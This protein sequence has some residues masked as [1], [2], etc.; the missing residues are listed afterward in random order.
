MDKGGTSWQYQVDDDFPKDITVLKA[1]S[2][3]QTKD[4]KRATTEMG[5]YNHHNVFMDISKPPGILYGCSNGPSKEKVPFS[6]FA[7]G[8]TESGSIDFLTQKGDLK[9]GYYLPN[10]RKLTNM[11]DVINYNN[12]ERELY[13]S[14]ELEYLT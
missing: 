12:E 13:T 6:V 7:A 3:V 2:E 8:A 4:F 10:N 11:I 1:A 5:I 14:T 9:T